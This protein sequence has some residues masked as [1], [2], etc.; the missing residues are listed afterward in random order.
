MWQVDMGQM[1]GM[2][3]GMR[4][5][6]MFMG[7]PQIG[8]LTQG[9]RG[10]PQVG[11]GGEACRAPQVV[12]TRTVGPIESHDTREK[13]RRRVGEPVSNTAPLLPSLQWL[14]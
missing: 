4:M 5:G 9:D 7:Q 14:D 13:C 10:Q 2:D 8:E 11:Q 3:G 1:G 6:Q 12:G